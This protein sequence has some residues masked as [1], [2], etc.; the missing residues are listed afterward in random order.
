MRVFKGFS[1][2]GNFINPVVTTGSFD[3]VHIGH[4]AII[5]R[6][7]KLAEQYKGETVLITFHP[8]PR[9][10]LYPDTEGKNLRLITTL[11]EKLYLLE[12]AGVDNVIVAGFTTEFAKTTSEQFVK[13]YLKGIIGARVIVVGFNHHFGWRKKGDFNYL[14]G[15]AKKYGF[16]AEEI[17]EKEIQHET[18]SS[19]RIRN[20]LSEGYIQRANAYLDD[21]FMIIS[22]VTSTDALNHTGFSFL[23]VNSHH[24]EDKLLPPCGI[25]AISAICKDIT[26]RG[27]LLIT[28]DNDLK[29][30]IL[31]HPFGEKKN[32]E[33]QK[34]RIL[35]HKRIADESCLKENKS[36]KKILNRAFEEIN[37][38][39]F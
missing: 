15:L 31:L 26:T 3:G 13:D 37:E 22:E 28:C 21:Y 17:P 4:K 2:A 34:I 5:N 9:K 24:E 20:A 14:L 27:M 12:K 11:E 16:D 30:R 19:T 29:I 18:V 10:I 8:H 1:E 36:L 32:I 23:E 7:K 6:L 33:H 38:L 35:F 39:I 25:Y